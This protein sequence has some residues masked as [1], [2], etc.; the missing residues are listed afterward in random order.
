MHSMQKLEIKYGRGNLVDGYMA[1]LAAT[2]A[3]NKA[4]SFACCA[5]SYQLARSSIDW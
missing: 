1:S 4:R 5:C 3:L 2:I